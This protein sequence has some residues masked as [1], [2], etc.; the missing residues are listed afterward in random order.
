MHKG[1]TVRPLMQPGF[2]RRLFQRPVPENGYIEL[3]NLL[4]SRA[5]G[6]MHAGHVEQ[7][8][9]AHGVRSMDRSRAKAMYG[10]AILAFISDDVLTDAEATDLQHLRTLLG[11]G[12][13]EA[14]EVECEVVHPR[15][16]RRIAEVL[17]DEQVTDSERDAL[18][19]LR[20]ALRIDERSAAAIWEQAAEPILT[21]RWQAA[22]S[23]R[24]L[25]PDERHA[26]DALARN[27]G[28]TVNIDAA[29]KAQLDRFHWYWLMEHGTFPDVGAPINLPRGERCHFSAP[30]QMYEMRTETQRVHYSGASVRIRIMKGVYYRA[31]TVS[32][33]R[34]TRDVLRLI[35][36]GTLYVTSKRVIFDGDRKNTT[37]RLSN[38]LSVTPYSDGVEI[39]KTSGRNTIF[40]VGDPEWLVVLLS[41]RLAIES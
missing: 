21:R 20:R 7:A 8:L 38:V 6:E 23:D 24:R 34:I 4:A 35:D 16:Q 14:A 33:Q 32:A 27:F 17:R 18:N 36:S 11:I 28:L 25:S 41:S 2:F 31:G 15:Y 37:I 13:A 26:L 19:T 39:E 9:R 12:D 1:F 40:T 10:K 22:V 3:E 5:W 30:A 29:T